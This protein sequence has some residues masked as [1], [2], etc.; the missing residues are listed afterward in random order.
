MG[1]EDRITKLEELLQSFRE[2]REGVA[3]SDAEKRK[4]RDRICRL[5][6]SCRS[7][8]AETDGEQPIEIVGANGEK[9]SFPNPFEAALFSGNLRYAHQAESYLQRAIGSLQPIASD[10]VVSTISL[11]TPQLIQ[12]LRRL[13]ECCQY[14]R[15]PLNDENSIKDVIWIMLRC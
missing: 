13:R 9:R 1:V 10:P 5:H 3:L 7:I 4:L 2:Y 11:G 14:I 12:T 15:T 6:G 8:L